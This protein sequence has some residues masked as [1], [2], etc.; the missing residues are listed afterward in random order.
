MARRSNYNQE[1]R[2]KELERQKKKEK[3]K[4]RKIEREQQAPSLVE[5]AGPVDGGTGNLYEPE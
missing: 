4:V 2:L 1:K 3:K 5:T